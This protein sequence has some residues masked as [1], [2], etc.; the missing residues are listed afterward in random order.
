MAQFLFCE[1]MGRIRVVPRVDVGYQKIGF[2]LN[3]PVPFGFSAGIPTVG[4][5]DLT[6]RDSNVWVGSV[7]FDAQIGPRLSLFLTGQANAKR[8]VTV[9]EGESPSILVLALGL[10]LPLQRPGTGLEWWA[11][12]AGAA[13]RI[14]DDLSLIGGFRQDNL[15]LGLGGPRTADGQSLD[16][17]LNIPGVVSLLTSFRGDLQTKL[18]IPYFGVQFSGFNYRGSV[19]L[20]PFVWATAKV[21]LRGATIIGIP[22][23]PLEIDLFNEWRFSLSKPAFFLEG[24]SEY[25][26]EVY[27]GGL[28]RLWA[29]GNWLRVRDTANENYNLNLQAFLGPIPVLNATLTDAGSATSTLTRY[30]LA[31]GISAVIPF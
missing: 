6:L 9:E 4:P 10:P 19:I 17:N 27:R 21:P 18:S 2:S 22:F 29:T 16:L 23:I 13:W 8:D 26:V 20:S 30:L 11:I 1:L 12:D 25:D 3:V 28:I 15:S 24:K 7:G 31:G 14:R 5:V